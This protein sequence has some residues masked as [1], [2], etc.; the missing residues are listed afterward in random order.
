MVVQEALR[1]G[2]DRGV[3]GRRDTDLTGADAALLVTPRDSGELAAAVLSVL[4]DEGLASFDGGGPRA[5]SRTSVGV[6]RGRCGHRRVR[7]LAAR[8]GQP[9]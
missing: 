5:G 7:R 6:R 8:R 3:P 2:F 4:R 9:G 1:A